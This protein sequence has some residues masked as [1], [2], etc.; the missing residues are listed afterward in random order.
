MPDTLQLLVNAA[1]GAV[2][3][4]V[5]LVVIARVLWTDRR[6]DQRTEADNARLR[7]EV[8]HLRADLE[9]ALARVLLVE[10][11]LV[12]AGIELPEGPPRPAPLMLEE[13]SHAAR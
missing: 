2:A 3:T 4:V 10:A 6:A 1:P 13:E 5:A 11:T 7:R 8:A 9:W 12:R